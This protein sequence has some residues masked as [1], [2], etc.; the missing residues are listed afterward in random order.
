MFEIWVKIQKKDPQKRCS[1]HQQNSYPNYVFV[2]EVD[3]TP[4]TNEANFRKKRER[5]SFERKN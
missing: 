4:A 2:R 5:E 3:I 1:K